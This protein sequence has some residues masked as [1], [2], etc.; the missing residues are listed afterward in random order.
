MI[1]N[2]YSCQFSNDIFILID[3]IDKMWEF[4]VRKSIKPKSRAICP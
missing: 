2:L 4:D 3:L 1:N